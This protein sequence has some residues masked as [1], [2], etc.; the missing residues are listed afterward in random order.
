MHLQVTN[1]SRHDSF[2]A[3][4]QALQVEFTHNAGLPWCT[5]SHTIICSL[6]V[7]QG[8]KIGPPVHHP[9]THAAGMAAQ[10]RVTVHS[11]V[12]STPY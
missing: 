8:P 4:V 1:K 10:I 7:L 6:N 12:T 9:A 2:A 5:R 11:Q 3:A